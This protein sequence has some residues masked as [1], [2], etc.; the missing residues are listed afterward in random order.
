MKEKNKQTNPKDLK[1]RGSQRCR[2]HFT[3]SSRE[4][5]SLFPSFETIDYF[6][7]IICSGECKMPTGTRDSWGLSHR[8]C[9]A[10]SSSPNHRGTKGERNGGRKEEG[11]GVKKREGRREG[12]KENA[13]PFISHQNLQNS[14]E[15]FLFSIIIRWLFY[16]L[17]KPRT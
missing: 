8:M 11:G 17:L 7:R 9:K 12:K 6:P 4:L 13:A 14:L 1:K 2:V 16:T 15:I 5:K 10:L 3:I